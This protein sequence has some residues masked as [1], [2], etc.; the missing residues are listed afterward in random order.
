MP[1]KLR[2]SIPDKTYQA[3]YEKGVKLLQTIDT[4]STFVLNTQKELK[5]IGLTDPTLCDDVYLFLTKMTPSDDGDENMDYVYH[6]DYTNLVTAFYVP[7]ECTRM[8]IFLESK[9]KPLYTMCDEKEL[10]DV[11]DEAKT[12]PNILHDLD[13]VL[14]MSKRTYINYYNQQD[15]IIIDGKLYNRIVPLYPVIPVCCS[16]YIP[17]IHCNVDTIYM[18][19]IVIFDTDIDIMFHNHTWTCVSP[20]TG[21][22][23]TYQN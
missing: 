1:L 17:K 6:V 7:E 18:E 16:Y 5:Y 2:E 15:S 3:D 10:S 21:D 9:S 23:L 11:L 20:T 12:V 13:R 22:I 4:R 14:L 8:N 19:N